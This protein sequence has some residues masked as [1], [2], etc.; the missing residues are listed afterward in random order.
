MLPFRNI[1]AERINPPL[2]FTG[3][4]R[5]AK[6]SR[7]RGVIPA[8]AG[9]QKIGEVHITYRSSQNQGTHKVAENKEFRNILAE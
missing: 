6:R 7:V 3:E 1:L 8:K 4:V 5:G 2:P 9:I